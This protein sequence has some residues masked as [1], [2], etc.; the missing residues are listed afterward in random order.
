MVPLACRRGV[1]TPSSPKG[2]DRSLSFGKADTVQ[3]GPEQAAG[4][5]GLRTSVPHASS[6]RATCFSVPGVGP[7]RGKAS[8]ETGPAQHSCDQPSP[9]AQTKP[10]S[11]CSERFSAKLS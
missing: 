9:R 4:A 2:E 3:R 10:G 6:P 5:G 11:P 1:N 7:L 8:R